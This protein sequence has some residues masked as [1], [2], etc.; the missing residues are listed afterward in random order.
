[1]S[2]PAVTMPPHPALPPPTPPSPHIPTCR[3]CP[4]SQASTRGHSILR[5]SPIIIVPFSTDN[6]K[7]LLLNNVNVSTGVISLLS[8]GPS[9]TP[10]P[11]DP[12]D[13]AALQ[14]D[15]LNWK[16][17]MRWAFLFRSKTL[18]EDPKAD[19][20]TTSPFIKPPWYSKTDKMAPF[21]SEEVELF[22]EMVRRTFASPSN[23]KPFSPNIS[24]AESNAF[25]ELRILKQNGFPVFLQDKSSRFVIASRETVK[26]KVDLDL[27]DAARYVSMEEDDIQDILTQIGKWWQRSKLHL[28][29]LEEDISSWLIN[30]EARAGKLKALIKTHKPNIPVREVFSVCGQPVE[31]LSSFIQ[32]SYLGPII[33]SGVLRWGLR[34]TKELVQ[35]LHE[36]NDTIRA[37]HITSTLSVC[38]LDIKNM[39]PSIYK[40]LAL[41]AIRLQLEK[42]G[43]SQAE[44]KAVLEALEI[45]CDGT[46]VYWDGSVI[47][48]MDGC[49]LGQAD[50]CDYCDIALDYFL[51]LVVPK[52]DNS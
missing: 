24:S 19:L 48:Q 29:V 44:I 2:L 28:S 33:A 23:H 27:N 38:T 22:M 37:D 40:D 18:R 50:S 26:A 3:P 39:F 1:M 7:P 9:F 30:P 14:E 35:F 6:V 36:V 5:S 10:T 11:L 46:R 45:V 21:A 34:D 16:E 12:P 47:K 13:S 25:K 41:P 43:H 17:R 49:S 4:S 8:K 52:L 20:S 15:I 32:F 51:Q 42:R 31:N